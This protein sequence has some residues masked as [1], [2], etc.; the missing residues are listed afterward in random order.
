MRGEV[1]DGVERIM[2]GRIQR[3]I[4]RCCQSFADVGVEVVGRR[5]EVAAEGGL[6][7]GVE[8]RRIVGA[9]ELHQQ[10]PVVGDELGEQGDR[11]QRQEQPQ[12]PPATAVGAEV[13]ET[14]TGQGR[15]T[16]G[17][18]ESLSAGYQEIV[19]TGGAPAP[20][21]AA[22]PG[23]SATPAAADAPT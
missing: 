3:E 23:V 15:K 13:A 4:A 7:I 16:P 21:L 14:P 22:R 20:T 12:R 9:V 5:R 2:V 19:T 1:V 11:E 10:R 8:H 17:Q 18:R 6:G